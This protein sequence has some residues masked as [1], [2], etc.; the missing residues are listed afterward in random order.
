MKV[1][2][3]NISK[4]FFKN[5]VLDGVD[6]V[7]DD[8]TVLALC[9][10]NGAGKSTLMKI[11]TGMVAKDEGTILIDGIEKNYS[12]LKEAEK[13][14][15]IFIHQELNVIPDMTVEENIFLGKEINKGGILD[16]KTM[17]KE[18]KDLMEKLGVEI[19]PRATMSKLS[20]G[21]QQMV[22]IAKALHNDVKVLI[23]DEPTS[24]LTITE[25]QVLFRIIKSLKERGVSI[26]YIS[27]RMEEI[28]EICDKVTV[29]RDGKCIATKNISEVSVDDVVKMMIG[30]EIGDR[31]PKRDNHFGETIF[32]VKHLSSAPYVRDVSFNLREGEIL[33]IAGLMGAGRSETMH[34]IFGSIKKDE[35]EIDIEGQA[36]H[37]KNPIEAKKHGIAFITED[38]KNEGLLLPFSIK[39]NISV[40]NLKK[41]SNKLGILDKN[42]EKKMTEEAIKDFSIKCSDESQHVES[43]SG[44]NQQKVVFAKWV[45]TDPKILILD[46]PTR[47]VDVGAKKEIYDIMN[48]LTKNGVS[49]I[50]ISSELPEI[51]GM[52]DRVVVLHE[53]KSVGIVEGSDINEEKIMNLA[54]RGV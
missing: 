34:T 45:T 48:D 50:M 35:G 51:I 33:G 39:F 21:K 28:F 42:K 44:G 10:E 6:L 23:M 9:G 36:V 24:A 47:G 2:M 49:I 13:D 26:V 1:E 46:E 32:E 17:R 30:R 5:Q 41:L 25:T 4:A 37:I 22:E 7:I 43:L 40:A 16:K 14:G 53:G 15:L 8:A 38:R 27:H 19:D 3:K 52:S 31:Y 11:L 54:T 29:L 18:T 20:V 12:H